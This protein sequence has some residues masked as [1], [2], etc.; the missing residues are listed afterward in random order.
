LFNPV[1][2]KR[3]QGDRLV[4]I[5]YGDELGPR[6]VRIERMKDLMLLVSFD[7]V[8][9][10]TNPGDPPK[11]QI[12]VQRETDANPRPNRRIIGPGTPRSDL[13]E[14][15]STEGP[16]TDPT[17]LVLRVKDEIEPITVSRDKPFSRTVGYAADLVYPPGK[18]T[19][20]HRRVNDQ[21]KLD[22]H[23]ETYKIVA[24]TQNEVVLSADSNKRRHVIKHHVDTASTR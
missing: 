19:F 1:P 2:W 13:V 9:P 22:D 4:P 12:I 15:V 17:A 21:I 20:N 16:P 14:L 18:Q 10:S 6:A 23:P 7:S 5:R 8:V 3:V 24:I 11:Y